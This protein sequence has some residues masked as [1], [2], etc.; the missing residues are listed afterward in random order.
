MK[1]KIGGLVAVMLV[2]GVVLCN[3]VG[4]RESLAADSG[5]GP[6]V[7]ATSMVKISK[8]A[9]VVIM[10]A[11][12]V[13]NHEIRILFTT[14][15]GLIT[16]IKYSLKPQ[17]VADKRGAWVTTWTCGRFI[18]KKL[19]KEGVYIITAADGDYNPLSHA[20]VFFYV[21]KKAEETSKKK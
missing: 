12:F 16:D 2:F 9:E 17:P 10:G 21:E 13:P 4:S 6:T 7:V 15:D 14:K 5:L 11:G 19:I 1:K 8:K 3:Y 18:T 20:P